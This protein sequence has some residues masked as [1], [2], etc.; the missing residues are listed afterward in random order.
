VRGSGGS[1][2]RRRSS[3]SSATKYVS[4]T[5]CGLPYHI[6]GAIPERDSLLLQTPESLAKSLA[7]DVRTGQE[8]LRID[9]EAKEVEVRDL[10]ERRTYRESYDKLVLCPGAEPIRPPIPGADDPRVVVAAMTGALHRYLAARDSLVDEIRALVPFNLRPLEEPLARELGNRFGLVYL[11]L[12]VGIEDPVERLAEV[13]RRMD[14]I[15]HSPEGAVSYGILGTMGLTPPA[16]EQRLLDIFTAKGSAVMTNVPGPRR[17]VWFAGSK[18]GGVIA[19]VPTAGTAAVG[20]SIFSY[21]GRLT[22]GFQVDAGLVPDPER[23]V[24]GFEHEMAVLG[25]LPGPQRRPRPAR[26]R[27]LRGRDPAARHRV[28]PAPAPDGD[29]RAPGGR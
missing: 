18:V 23:I 14:A 26:R 25:A 5:N 15:K 8:V 2:S 27:K 11:P 16:V 17:P 4:F 13:H 7:L 10:A 1:T 9:R 6:G 22:V 24:A 19:W 21:A 12:P 28:R 29:G 20:V 3:C